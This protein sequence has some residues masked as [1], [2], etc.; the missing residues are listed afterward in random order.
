M[1][2]AGR[3]GWHPVLAR[4]PDW[5]RDLLVIDVEEGDL[6]EAMVWLVVILGLVVGMTL[7]L[8]AGYMNT[9]KERAQRAQAQQATSA[10]A[11]AIVFLP[12][13]FPSPQPVATPIPFVF[14]DG[15]VTRLENHVRV[16]QALVAQ[17]VHH[18]SI[19]NLY[20]QPASPRPLH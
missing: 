2:Q 11:D 7:M 1:I 10:K 12:G 16:E 4:I 17:F 14:D 5:E 9:G 13:F 8:A 19:D 20:R 18:P 6:M 3:R 15:L